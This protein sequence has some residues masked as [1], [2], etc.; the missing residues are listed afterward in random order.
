M[1]LLADGLHNLRHALR[2]WAVL[3]HWLPT[4]SSMSSLH[5]LLGLPL[6]RFPSLGVHSDVIF[7]HLV[8][9]ILATCPAHCPFMH[10]TFSIISITPVFDLIISFLILS[11]L[12]M[13]NNDL[14][15]LRWAT[16]SF[17]S[18]CFVST[19]KL[20]QNLKFTVQ[21]SHTCIVATSATVVTELYNINS[22]VPDQLE[23]YLVPCTN[24]GHC[25][26]APYPLPVSPVYHCHSSNHYQ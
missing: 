23:P 1:P 26:V 20:N 3:I 6:S 5:L 2:S 13:F 21:S 22:A 25:T 7:A 8:F 24:I 4:A 9:F 12:V 18:R 16:A 14:S 10:F 11:L 19:L 17:L 15:M